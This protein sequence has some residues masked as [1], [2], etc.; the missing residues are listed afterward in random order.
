M[1]VTPSIVPPEVDVGDVRTV[2]HTVTGP[3]T[4]NSRSNGK[5][6]R[7]LH[8][9]MEIATIAISINRLPM[10]NV[11]VFDE[12]VGD[13]SVVGSAFNIFAQSGEQR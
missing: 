13:S 6:F 10:P 11:N 2:Y 3:E 5:R 12:A 1:P 4:S 9:A 8:Q 7:S